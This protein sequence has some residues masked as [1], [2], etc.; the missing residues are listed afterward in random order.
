MEPAGRSPTPTPAPAWNELR[1]CR[2]SETFLALVWES[3]ACLPLC[4][5]WLRALPGRPGRGGWRGH[6]R[7]PGAAPPSAQRSTSY[8]SKP[9][10]NKPLMPRASVSPDV[11]WTETPRD[12]S[13]ALKNDSGDL[14]FLRPVS[15]QDPL[16]PRE[17]GVILRAAGLGGSLQELL[18]ATLNSMI[19]LKRMFI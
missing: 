15:R 1:F 8:K 16:R 12:R 9:A 13:Q 19:L 17:P 10:S 11:N 6:F 7:S 2:C 5:P 18:I 3:F 4:L 14:C